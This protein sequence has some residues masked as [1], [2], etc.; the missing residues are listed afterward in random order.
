M[1]IIANT[2]QS[3]S[4]VGN[5]EELS[6]VVDR[7]TPEDTPVY[8]MI[9]KDTATSVHPEWEIDDLAPP[10][11]NVQTEGDEYAFGAISPPVRVGNY[12]QIFRKAFIISNTQ[13][14]V[15]NAGNVM[16]RKYQKAKRGVEIR[17]DVELSI[18]SNVGSVGGATRVSAGLPAWLTTNVSRGA[19]GANGGFQVGTGLVTPAT[20]GTQRAFTKT[21]L[22]TVMSQAYTSG[23]NVTTLVVSPY[24][25]SVFVTFMS[26]A[27]VAPFRTSVDGKG[28]NTL[29][30]NADYYEGP[31]GMVMVKPDRVMA[32]NAESAR[33]AMLIDP[34]TLAWTWLRKI[35]EDKNIAKTGDADKCVLIGEGCLKV[36]NQAGN[37][38]VA[39][40]FGLTAAS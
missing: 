28:K 13:E 3:T 14:A 32:V 38:I 33:R 10:A 25:K 22:D 30:A 4:A 15:E 2:F 6:D 23:A 18:L 8:S 20:N 37:G 16:K 39:D 11:A 34:D 24:V 21:L 17:K 31:Y 29:V 7:I 35:A 5:R 36:K 9:G 12:T 1:A 27:N 40:V 26:D 19:T